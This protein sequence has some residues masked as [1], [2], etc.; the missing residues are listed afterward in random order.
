[1]N[2]KEYRLTPGGLE[3]LKREL[4]TLKAR[5]LTIAEKLKNA[6]ELGDLS[7]NAEYHTA[8]EEQIQVEGR[9]S[10]I[11]HVVSHVELIQTPKDKTIVE[12]GNTVTLNNGQDRHLTVVGS[13]EADPAENRISDE[14]P[15]GKAI[16]GKKVGDK[17]EI[18]TP[19]GKTVY[20]VKDI[21]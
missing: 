6:R 3:E 15:L 12:L 21:K 8:R 11:E 17:V 9:I 19:A 14:S 1:M 4:E 18:E 13:V 10:D 7:E 16:L 2:K 20:T 5:R